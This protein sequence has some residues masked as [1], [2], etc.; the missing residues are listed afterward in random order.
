MLLVIGEGVVVMVGIGMVVGICIGI[1][2][3]VVVVDSSKLDSRE[4]SVRWNDENCSVCMERFFLLDL[5]D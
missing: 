1:C 2:V 4:R 3:W 5:L